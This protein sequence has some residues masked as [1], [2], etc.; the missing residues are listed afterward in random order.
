[1]KK[2]VLDYVSEKTKDLLAAPMTCQELKDASQSWLDAIG[3]ANEAEVTKS[4]IAELEADI[5]PIDSLIGYAS[6][7]QGKQYFGEE[8]ANDIVKHSEE[9]KANGAK[10][11]D[12][13]AC[14]AVAAI[15]D[16]KEEMLQ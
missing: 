5:M 14:S 13:Q 6:S 15:L 2:E 4:F 8:A 16:K 12:C 10:Y 11:C 7:E 9:I 3:T 1:M